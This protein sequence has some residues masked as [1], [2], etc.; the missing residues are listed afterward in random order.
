MSAMGVQNGTGSGRGAGPAADGRYANCVVGAKSID[1]EL[2]APRRL[3]SDEQERRLAALE[4]EI[5]RSDA[6]TQIA[7][8]ENV[9]DV[10]R[11]AE[12]QPP[13]SRTSR[14]DGDERS[15]RG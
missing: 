2:S 13:R 12:R 6:E 10:G 5:D 7:V 15:V 1:P 9:D 4:I 8:A 11:S 3:S 14:V